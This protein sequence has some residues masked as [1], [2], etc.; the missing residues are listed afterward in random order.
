MIGLVTAYREKSA[1][2]ERIPVESLRND[3]SAR[4]RKDV[5][6]DLAE[7]ASA[8]YDNLTKF[9]KEVKESMDRVLPD[10]ES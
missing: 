9:L 7:M 5:N 1:D 2:L 6:S 4:W 3:T 10:I 8:T